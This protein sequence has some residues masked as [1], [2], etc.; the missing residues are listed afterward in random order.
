MEKRESLQN[1]FCS[2]IKTDSFYENFRF[3]NRWINFLFVFHYLLL[4]CMLQYSKLLKPRSELLE[5]LLLCNLGDFHI[6]LSLN[7]F[8]F[9][10]IPCLQ[11]KRFKLTSLFSSLNTVT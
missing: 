6:S 8:C 9:I 1:Q 11:I 3:S 10:C 5:I 4:L 2:S 7:S